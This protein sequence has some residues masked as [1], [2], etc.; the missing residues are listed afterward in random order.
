VGFGDHHK[1]PEQDS[2]KVLITVGT[3]RAPESL[4]ISISA[5]GRTNKPKAKLRSNNRQLSMNRDTQD[6]FEIGL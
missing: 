4:E 2:A 1:T 3:A 5:Y 6:Q